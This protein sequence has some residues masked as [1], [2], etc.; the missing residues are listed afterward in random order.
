MAE[1]AI[2]YH[3]EHHRNT[4]KL[5]EQAAPE[6]DLLEV[7]G[8]EGTDLSVYRAVG[9]ASGV[10]MSRLHPSVT[11]FALSHA[12]ELPGGRTFV[13]YTCGSGGKKYA[14][15]FVRRLEDAG[16][17]TLGVFSCKGYDT[18]GPFGLIGGIAKGRP[19]ADDAAA[20]AEFLR[21]T[22]QSRL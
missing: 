16:V 15:G 7:S 18:Y 12:R 9:F 1:I 21:E 17:R 19:D 13:L 20:A 8:A 6:A 10:Y 11:G 4:K 14:D 5:L 22:V 3:S 2:L